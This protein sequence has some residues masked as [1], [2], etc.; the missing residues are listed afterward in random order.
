MIKLF[1]SS[2]V[3]SFFLFFLSVDI[4]F[5]GTDNRKKPPSSDDWKRTSIQWAWSSL[6]L[7]QTPCWAKRL[8]S[9]CEHQPAENLNFV[10]NNYLRGWISWLKAAQLPVLVLLPLF[11]PVT[12]FLASPP[13]PPHSSK[14]K[15][16]Q[17]PTHQAPI[18]IVFCL[19]FFLG[20]PVSQ[21]HLIWNNTELK[22]DYCLNDYK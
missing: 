10:L 3:T 4:K 22:D 1:G 19:F 8:N 13:L 21:Q 18:L 11:F 12:H 2:I 16:P 6:I 17:K 9:V 14:S 20:I 15:I 5:W 7:L